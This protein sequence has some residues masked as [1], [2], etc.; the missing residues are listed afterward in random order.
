MKIYPPHRLILENARIIRERLL[1]EGIAD[2]QITVRVGEHVGVSDVIAQGT[3][4]SDYRIIDVAEALGIPADNTALLSKIITVR[5]GQT[6][7]KGTPL[8]EAPKRSLRKLIPVSPS[9]AIVRLVEHG[10]VILEIDP[11]TI[12]IKARLVGTVIEADASW[13]VSIETIGTVIQCAWGNG[14][15]NAC[16]F[17]FEPGMAGTESEGSFKGLA[18]LLNYDIALSPYRGKAIILTRPLQ[19]LDLDVVEAHELGGIVA[20]WSPPHLRERAMMLKVPVILTE[21][22]GKLPPTSYL[23]DLLFQRRNTQAIF[24]AT[25]LNHRTNSRP[26][27]I[28]VG[29]IT[30]EK[31]VTPQV[32]RPLEVGM[33]V[34]MARAPYAGQIGVISDLP[35]MLIRIENGLRVSCAQVKL[36]TGETVIVPQVNLE[37]L[38]EAV[39]R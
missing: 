32:E 23:F 3:F 26:E 4:A 29:G 5:A 39:A 28:I 31:P 7:A 12:D 1:P 25:P 24:D 35:E 37:S 38:G 22:F 14:Q 13:G 16:G 15:F 21:G 20:P 8:G 19:R 17:A 11:E 6:L 9:K 2:S 34:R 30:R 36:G 10:R 27:I 33:R 18:D